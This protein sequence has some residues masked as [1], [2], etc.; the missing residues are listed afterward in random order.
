MP[1]QLPRWSG[2]DTPPGIRAWVDRFAGALERALTGG[3]QL[4]VNAAPNGPA[5]GSLAGTYPAPSQLSLRVATVVT[6]GT[7]TTLSA[8][9]LAGGVVQRSG[10]A[11]AFTDMTDTAAHILTALAAPQRVVGQSF[12]TMVVNASAAVMTLAAGSGVSLAGNTSAGGFT[13]AAGTTRIFRA[14]VT[15]TAT[16]TITIYG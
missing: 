9:A 5:G 16:P 6:A 14:I 4:G 13:L 10:P 7:G 12:E 8:A 1:I 3:A 2:A 11:S 15:A